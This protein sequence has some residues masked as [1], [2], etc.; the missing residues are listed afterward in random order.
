MEYA[1]QRVKVKVQPFHVEC[2]SMC[3]SLF[4]LKAFFCAAKKR[5]FFFKGQRVAEKNDGAWR[6]RNISHLL[7]HFPV[8]RVGQTETRGQEHPLGL[9]RGSQSLGPA[10]S[11]LHVPGKA[12]GLE[13]SWGSHGNGLAGL[14]NITLTCS[15]SRRVPVLLQCILFQPLVNLPWCIKRSP[16]HWW[17]FQRVI[18]S[19]PSELLTSWLLT[20]SR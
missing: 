2:F 12:V 1:Q 19:Q 17:L 18:I 11:A 7:L 6:R 5:F 3:M 16:Q 10:L 4:L 15:S 14:A 20:W 13:T 9:P 8:P